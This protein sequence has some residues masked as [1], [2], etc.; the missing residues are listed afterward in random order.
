MVNRIKVNW[1]KKATISFQSAIK[2]IK[3]DSPHNAEKIRKAI[4]ISTKELADY[5]HKHPSDRYKLNNDGSYRAYELYKYRIAYVVLE[6]E[7]KV[8]LFRHTSQEPFDY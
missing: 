6:K 7:I 5:P 4:L 1:D 8:I 2:Y 3:S